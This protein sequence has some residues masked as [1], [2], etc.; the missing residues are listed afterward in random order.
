MFSIN[1]FIYSLIP[2]FEVLVIL[3]FCLLLVL[4][5]Y[6]SFLTIFHFV[7]CYFR[8]RS[9]FT[10]YPKI[11]HSSTTNFRRLLSMPSFSQGL[12]IWMLILY[13]FLCGRRTCRTEFHQFQ[14][15]IRITV[16]YSHCSNVGRKAYAPVHMLCSK[17]C[18]ST[19]VWRPYCEF[20]RTQGPGTRGLWSCFVAREESMLLRNKWIDLVSTDP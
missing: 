17:K 9:Y 15:E 13:S 1:Q 18:A 19:P 14:V 2:Y 8:N 20:M 6:A 4:Q 5:T 16:H 12:W 3:H 10:L 7:P 11:S